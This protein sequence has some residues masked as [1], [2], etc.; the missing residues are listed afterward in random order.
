MKSTMIRLLSAG[1]LLFATLCAQAATYY[2][3]PSGNDANSG[4]SQAQA[5]RTIAR[6]QQQM[7][8]LQ[9]G[10]QVLFQRGGIYPGRLDISKSGTSSAPLVFGA[11]GSGTRPIISGGEPV[12]NWV[13]HQGN[14]WRAPFTTAP[15][16]VLVNNQ[17]MT[18]A[19]YPNHGW[20]RNEQ[21]SASSISSMSLGQPAG[22]WNGATVVVRTTNYSYERSTVTSSNTGSIQFDPIYVN[23][24]NDDWGFFLSGKLSE[25]DMPGEW[26][27]DAATG[28]LYLWAPDNANP[29]TLSI[30]ASIY[31]KGVV[32][33]WQK[34]HMRIE[35]LIIQ[36]QTAQGI[37]TEVSNNVVVNNCLVRHCYVGISSSGNNNHYTNN[38]IHHTF[39][40]GMNIYDTNALVEGN[41]FTDIAIEPGMGENHWGYWG[42]NAT[43]QG[44]V[45]R[46]NR[47]TNIG[48]SG[49]GV[50][51]NILV[52]KNVVVNANKILND[53]AGITF[54]NCN[55]VIVRDNIVMDLVGDL[56]SVATS[57]YVYYP[58]S[59][60]IYFGNTSI[61]NT[62]VERNTVARCNGAGIHV[63]H[64]MVSSGNQVKDNVIF[65]NNVQLS[66][67]DFSNYNGPGATA[68]YHVPSFNTIYSGNVLYS[69]RPEQLCMRQFHVYSQNHVDFGTFSNNRYFNPYNELSIR[70]QNFQGA[71]TK[72]YTLERWQSTFN[73]DAGS[74]R[75]PLRLSPYAVTDVLGTN[76]VPNGN[77]DYNVSGWGGWPTQAQ[78]THDMTYLDNGAMKVN[79]NN[80]SSY[81]VFFLYPDAML[82]LQNTAFYRLRFSIQ[83]NMQGN[84]DME[85]KNQSQLQTPY[86]MYTRKVP[87]STERRD[88]TI[89][90]QSSV[91][92]PAR[93]QFINHYTESTYWLDNV[94]VERVQVE[95]VDPYTRHVLLHN[96][97]STA[98][99]F[100]LTGCWSLVSGTIVTDEITVPAYGSVV[101]QKEDDTLCGLTTGTNEVFTQQHDLL[102]HPNPAVAGSTLRL[103]EPVAGDLHVKLMDAS[104]RIVQQAHLR[105]GTTTLD[106]QANIPQGLYLLQ[107]IQ[108]EHSNTQ[109]IVLE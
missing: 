38:T 28:Q 63:D 86:P 57:H 82:D 29:N 17:P 26:Y 31:D 98:Q 99:T 77:F 50:G 70:I 24:Q 72:D 59:F 15:K 81:D 68:P 33:G 76:Q 25:L 2:V 8:S 6:V 30:L 45:I 106:L 75:S 14:I 100:T 61:T 1:L 97:Q 9:P 12:T 55:G 85:V 102:F 4:T 23:L 34:A 101:L 87:F 19:R 90:F 92:E 27:H 54:D 65:D 43:G 78:V 44:T 37:S 49:I 40:A 89:F 13:Q 39:G 35:N 46:S 64:T 60:G 91:T 32:P 67:S 52:E 7:N 71:G 51:A 21:G 88:M 103:R 10:D 93:L 56:E 11:Y 66:L 105:S 104:G 36:G 41:T 18:H 107:T 5:W 22:Y 69:V 109:R 3:S 16:Y 96:D 58:I 73:E 108:G 83:S 95:P 94:V 79:F 84:V 53:G 42:I 47:L 62:I 80:N 74:T 20:L 48:Y